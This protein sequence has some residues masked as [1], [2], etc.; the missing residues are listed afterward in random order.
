MASFGNRFLIS[1]TA[2]FVFGLALL[3]ERVGRYFH[4]ST[5]AFV[6]ASGLVVVL[7]LWN[8]GFIFQWGEH[9]I[10]VRGEISFREVIHNQ[11]FVVPRQMGTHLWAYLFKR[12]DEMR[13]IEDRDIQQMNNGVSPAEQ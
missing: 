1:L 5:R 4:D 7:S 10:P 12:K 6:A 11:L 13:R 8:A 2:V 9:L 3:F